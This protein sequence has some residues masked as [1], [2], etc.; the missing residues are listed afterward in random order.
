MDNELGI[1]C[2]PRP[3]DEAFGATAKQMP[4]QQQTQE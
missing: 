2:F 1:L 3:E 4:Q